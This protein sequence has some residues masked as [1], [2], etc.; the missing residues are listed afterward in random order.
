MRI[1]AATAAFLALSCAAASAEGLCE[2]YGP[3]APRDITAPAGANPIGFAVAPGPAEMKL[4]NIHGHTPAEHRGPGFLKL[5]PTG[6]GYDCDAQ[7]SGAELMPMAGKFSG[8][9]PGD[10]FEVHWVFTSCDVG[11]GPGLEACSS[12]AC[13]NPQLRVEAQVFLLVNDPSA[14]HIQDFDWAGGAP[15]PK[16]L[17]RGETVVYSGSTTGPKYSENA[18]SPLQVTWSVR[19]GCVKLHIGSLHEWAETNA[20]EENHAHGV[21]PLVTARPLLSSMK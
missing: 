14:A 21:R 1:L 3:Q 12:A 2:G 15:Q 20:F 16:S 18:C 7:L 4:C 5:A 9:K 11:P 13:A 8:V 19:P 10:A 17:P 6:A